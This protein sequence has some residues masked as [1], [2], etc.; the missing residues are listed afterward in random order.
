[1]TTVG[2]KRMLSRLPDLTMDLTIDHE[3]RLV[4][5][6]M[7]HFDSALLASFVMDVLP[8]DYSAVVAESDEDVHPAGLPRRPAYRLVVVLAGREHPA[9]VVRLQD[10]GVTVTLGDP[11]AAYLARCSKSIEDLLRSLAVRGIEAVVTCIDRYARP[12]PSDGFLH[13]Y[14][15]TRD[16]GQ[17]HVVAQACSETETV[18][19]VS[20]CVMSDAKRPSDIDQVI[21]HEPHFA[22]DNEARQV[23][24]RNW[25]PERDGAGNAMPAWDDSSRRGRI[26]VR[27]N[28]RWLRADEFDPVQREAWKQAHQVFSVEHEGVELFPGYQFRRF[29]GQWQ[30]RPSIRGILN[31][32]GPVKHPWFLAAWFQG[33]NAWLVERDGDTQR[34]ISPEE[35]LERCRDDDVVHAARRSWT[36]Q[37]R[38]DN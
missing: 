37:S 34:S 7:R 32:L 27:T 13:L 38:E 10:G 11:D 15:R 17:E 24:R 21:A 2:V 35:A 4:T 5:L 18:H 3:R 23:V 22:W 31:A 36:G 26:R 25:E 1:M 29:K 30:P 33:A 6:G 9:Q 19:G 12:A 28:T 8:R 14:A 16:A 20:I